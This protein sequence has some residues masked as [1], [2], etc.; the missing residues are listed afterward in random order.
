MDEVSYKLESEII[1]FNDTVTLWTQF[2]ESSPTPNISEP[3]PMLPAYIAY[4]S[5]V[6]FR[7]VSIKMFQM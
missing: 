2:Q 1:N 3:E 6:L 4:T 7:W 5:F